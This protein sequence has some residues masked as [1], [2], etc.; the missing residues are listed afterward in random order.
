MEC[1]SSR[2]LC[3]DCLHHHPGL[4]MPYLLALESRNNRQP[5]CSEVQSTLQLTCLS[6]EDQLQGVR[7]E[8]DLLPRPI[9]RQAWR[10]PPV[11][12]GLAG[13]DFALQRRQFG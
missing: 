11:L 7:I 4:R 9:R 10:Q 13:E 5:L 1:D 3:K 12:P 2:H 8:G 6:T